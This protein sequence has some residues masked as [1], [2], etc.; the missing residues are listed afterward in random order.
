MRA[1]KYPFLVVKVLVAA[2]ATVFGTIGCSLFAN[3]PAE[4][5]AYQLTQDY[6]GIFSTRP[7]P[8]TYGFYLVKLKTAPL[9]A[10]AAK[11]SPAE[12]SALT[13][14]QDAIIKSL[15]TLSSDIKIVYR[16][17]L[18][19]NG[20]AIVAPVALEEKIGAIAGVSHLESAGLFA[21]PVVQ[22]VV[23]AANSPAFGRAIQ[24]RNSVKFIGGDVAHARGIRGQGMRI[25]VI[26]SGIDYTHA[27][28]G[29][30][31]T[32]AAYKAAYQEVNSG[33]PSALFPTAKVVGGVDF[34]GTEYDS[35]SPQF[36]KRLPILDMNP[37]DEGGHGTHVSGTIAGQGDGFNTY[38]GVAPEARLFAL[39]VFGANGSTSDSVVVAA[40]E[41]AAD[42]NGDGDTSDRLDVVNLSLGSGYGD[43][44][45]L[46]SEAIQRLSRSGT[47]VV[48]S[49]GNSG[50]TPYIVGSPGVAEDAISVA[51][52]VDDMEQNWMFGAVKFTT[53]DEPELYAEAIE[54]T[55]TKPLQ[56]VQSLTESLVYVGL[57]DADFSSEVAA[58]LKGH[59]AL[60]D[61]GAVSF[62]D[63]IRRS[64]VAGAMAVVMI[65]NQE[66]APFTMGGGDGD[67]FDI[68]GVMISKEIGTKL[69]AAIAKGAVVADLKTTKKI[70][71]PELIDTI[72]T[73]SSR[74]PR[75]IDALLKPEI[76]AP[77]AK[78]ISAKMGG[79]TAGVEM[80]GTSMAAPHMAGV[81]ALL[82]QHNPSMTSAELKSLA[83]STAK[84]MVDA[85]KKPYSLSRQGAGRMQLEKAL[86]QSLVTE[87]MAIS[88]GEMGLEAK[89]VMQREL[90]IK[91]TS[92]NAMTLK[93]GLREAAT[94]LKLAPVLP[95]VIEAK[96]AQRVALR[97]EIEGLGELGGLVVLVD[98]SG[99]E[100]ARIPVLSVV[101][102]VSQI[103][104]EELAVRSTS[105]LDSQGA[106]V[107]LTL[108]N[109]SRHDGTALP[110]NFISRDRRKA[111]PTLDQFQTTVCDLAETGYRVINKEG[112]PT[113][114][115][116]AKLYEPMTTWD[117]CEIS[118]L[119]D[120]DGDKLADQ[121]LV[122]VKQDHLEG[123]TAKT[124][125]SILLDAREAKRVRR[126]YDAAVVVPRPAGEK[127][128]V[129]D[130]KSAILGLEPMQAFD[131]SS[132]AVV[133]APLASIALRSNAGLAV[134]IATSAQ[135][136]S[137]IEPD[138]FFTVDPK[139]WATLN[140]KPG[141]A[142]FVDLPEVIAV[143]A[144]ET[145]TVSFTKGGDSG[146]LLLLF[147]EGRAV[148]GGLGADGQSA[149]LFPSFRP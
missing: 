105:S 66:G 72:A 48:C 102:T 6:N 147:P 37:L 122:G 82:K 60:I 121:E 109:G 61:R 16:Y 54:G 76:S 140:I 75:S 1:L 117:L 84:S 124:F 69:K 112:V 18:L 3:S 120:A 11:P 32:E 95:V 17:R 30:E 73:F 9:L 138:D 78:I 57:A 50:D 12:I 139:K 142:A 101:H 62:A 98:A 4:T 36:A 110:F 71:K 38:D 35:G 27:M 52:S 108:K 2:V 8:D 13:A 103:R 55:I 113:L 90:L 94:G 49:G 99:I 100:L 39:K 22:A 80:S 106:V 33:E 5:G 34:V 77:G 130:F 51:A 42:P 137:A 135:T 116:A 31:G 119:I 126:E 133:E 29:G 127:A 67:K 47:V 123:L 145:K 88:L 141:G 20:F 83:M 91:N 46:Y 23:Q 7:E 92:S 56:D 129:L 97:F 26:D 87:P 115:I 81:M 125:A 28:F 68:P 74:G 136:G 107:D 21:R 15:N 104:A 65:N 85:D 144:S 40:L 53:V 63:K 45:I 14:E 131:H 25:G 134:R 19:I 79:G 149:V 111:N 41:Y 148:L 64:V 132:V 89:K 118:V 143:K 86:A 128:P 24:Q 59:V 114:Q 58:A 43:G 96:A 93:V 44:H 70:E 10:A 146:G